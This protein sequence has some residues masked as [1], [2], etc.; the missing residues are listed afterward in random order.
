MAAR[1]LERVQALVGAAAVD[2]PAV[3]RSD[4]I[5]QRGTGGD[6]A[7]VAELHVQGRRA[8]S[9]ELETRRRGEADRLP[10]VGHEV[11]VHVDEGLHLV[12]AGRDVVEQ[13]EHVGC[14][15]RAGE[16]DRRFRAE[17]QQHGSGRARGDQDPVVGQGAEDCV[18]RVGG[19]DD[20]GRARAAR[21]A[22]RVHVEADRA[23]VE[24]AGCVRHASGEIDVGGILD[25]DAKG[26]VLVRI[27]EAVERALL[28]EVEIVVVAQ[29][30]V[31]AAV[32]GGLPAFVDIVVRAHD[33]VENAAAEVAPD[34]PE[35]RGGRFLEGR[36]EFIRRRVAGTRRD[37]REENVAHRIR[38]EAQIVVLAAG[39]EACDVGLR[40]RCASRQARREL[41]QGVEA[42]APGEAASSVGVH[43]QVDV[44]GGIHCQGVAL[45]GSAAELARTESGRGIIEAAGRHQGQGGIVFAH[46]GGTGVIVLDGRVEVAVG[47]NE[48]MGVDVGGEN[49]GLEH[50]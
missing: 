19:A 45:G 4:R 21:G 40:D 26:E 47:E 49:Q 11:V 17:R 34:R 35:R 22:A 36:A 20:H 46:D 44:A 25:R 48:R 29:G 10:R 38:G 50:A 13:I 2:G 1:S 39:D 24:I 5:G 37:Q 27:V 23:P 3:G 18:R 15:R 6:R 30:Q 16:A 9:A 33:H 31:V 8:G 42:L 14:E 32:G 7:A 28:D 43:D 12:L 41:E